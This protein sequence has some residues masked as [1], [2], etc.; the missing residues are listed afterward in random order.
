[1]RKSQ[2]KT[3][4]KNRRTVSWLDEMEE[5]KIV[6]EDDVLISRAQSGDDQA[7]VDLMR[8]Y[9]AFVYAIVIGIVN[10]SH[11]AEDIVQETF[12]NTYRGLSQL[13][14]TTKFKSWLA[15][16]ARETGYEN[17]EWTLFRSTR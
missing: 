10:N 1:M 7:F 5:L 3:A 9:H 4:R 8:A 13:E 14:D 2:Q 17:R 16:V 12:I 6:V 15:E 11:D